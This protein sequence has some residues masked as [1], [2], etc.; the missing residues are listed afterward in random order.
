MGLAQVSE[1]PLEWFEPRRD[2]SLWM[3]LPHQGSARPVDTTVKFILSRRNATYR[4]PYGEALLSRVY[5][6]WFFRY[7][8]WRFWMQF[9]ERFADPLITGQVFEPQAFVDAMN[10]LGMTSVIG[11]GKEETVS[12]TTPMLAGEFQRAE[13]ALV[14]RI[15]KVILGQTL[16][17]QVDGKGSYAAAQVHNEVRDDKRRADIRLVTGAVQDLINAM[18]TL[19][20]LTG[21]IPTF[22]MQDDTGLESARAE[23][24]ATLANANIVRFT[25]QYLLD[26]YDLDV[27]DFELP[28]TTRQ[29]G[30]LTA[31][32]L[33]TR[34]QRFTQDQA[35]VEHL[36]DTALA[37]SANPIPAEVLRQAIAQA[38]DPEDLAERLSKLYQGHD[39]VEFQAVV[40]R[41]LFA[42]DVLGYVNAETARG[43]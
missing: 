2:G 38:S 28:P 35:D 20:A 5:W 25:D 43:V 13:Q 14:G 10:G 4:S 42:A 6:P 8:G 17:S 24:D 27:G 30:T 7:N 18:W 16:T 29:T 40:E 11:V 22:V 23:R 9:L 36:A 21:D 26:R 3:T 41:A 15:Q 33:A 19:N 34:P 1:K 37:E 12:A 32:Q 31:L 39:A